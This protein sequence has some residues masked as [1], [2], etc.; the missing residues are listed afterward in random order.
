MADTVG[1]YEL[2][3]DGETISF[4][5]RCTTIVVANHA[6]STGDVLVKVAEINTT[7][8]TPIAPGNKEYFRKSVLSRNGITAVIV[9]ARTDT[10]TAHV[11]PV[12][13]IED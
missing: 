5:E 9:K 13:D 8:W 12:A 3:T 10:A 1:R 2:D 11:G 6:D 7:W 4:A